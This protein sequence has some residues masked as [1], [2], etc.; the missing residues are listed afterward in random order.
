MPTT[1]VTE[2]ITAFVYRI[3]AYMANHLID[4]P[5]M[6]AIVFC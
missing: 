6:L 5:A 3:T 2:T 4:D 1:S